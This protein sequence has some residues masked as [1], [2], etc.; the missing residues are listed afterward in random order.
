[1]YLVVLCAGSTVE[2]DRSF[3]PLTSPSLLQTVHAVVEINLDN[4]GGVWGSGELSG[5]KVRPDRGGR[6]A[7]ALYGHQQLRIFWA[8]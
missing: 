2:S 3:A 5:L 4:K 8:K 7:K 6:D 1:M